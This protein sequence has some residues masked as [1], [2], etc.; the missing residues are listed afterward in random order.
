MIDPRPMALAL[1]LARRARP[2]PNP[3]VGAVVVRDGRVVGRGFHAAAGGPHAEVVALRDAGAA[4]RGADLYVTLEPCNHH[5]RTPPCTEAILR[6]GVRRVVFGARDP[7]PRVRG[8]GAARLRAAGVDV[9]GGVLGGECAEAIAPFA[10]F[11]RAGLPFVTLKIAASLDGRLAART[12][13]SRWITGPAAR[14][15]VHELR[16]RH[17]AILVGASTV[18][19]DDPRLTVRLGRRAPDVPPPLRVVLARGRFPLPA[20]AALFRPGAPAPTLLAVAEGG[21]AARPR[22]ARVLELRPGRDGFVPERV[23]LRRLG[24]IGV[25]SVLVEG[26]GTTFTRFL[27][28]GVVDRIALFLGPRLLGGPGETCWLRGAGVD[29]PAAG[30]YVRDVRVERLGEDLLVLGRPCRRKGATPCSRGW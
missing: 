21:T 22:G 6:A 12:G 4:A 8:G 23:L 10:R 7:D 11:A 15:A 1:R 9:V 2:S 16:A 25:T 13:R 27:A 28:A 18:R 30:W 19:L 20:R 5:G 14:R 3:P 24:G 17:D 29:D 26:G